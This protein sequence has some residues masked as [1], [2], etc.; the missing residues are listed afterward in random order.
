MDK[1]ALDENYDLLKHRLR[2]KDEDIQN[3]RE[4]IEVL[5]NRI[6]S[7]DSYGKY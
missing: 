6:D 1:L 4:K 2:D 5:Q 3:Y 7:T